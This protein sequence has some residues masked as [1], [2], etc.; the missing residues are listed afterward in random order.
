MV[1]SD[2]AS[3]LFPEIGFEIPS[4]QKGQL[5]TVEGLLN[6]AVEGL[7]QDQPVR[8]VCVCVCVYV[9]VCVCVCVCACVC[10][11]CTFVYDTS[12]CM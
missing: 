4:G 5:T 7:Q 6:R 10:V 11:W 12:L 8:R 9:C 2:S 3:V 1:K